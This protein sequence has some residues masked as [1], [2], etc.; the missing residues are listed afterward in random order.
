MTQCPTMTQTKLLL[1]V[2]C[3][4]MLPEGTTGEDLIQ[5]IAEGP[6]IPS[7]GVPSHIGLNGNDIADSLAKSATAD[8]LRGDACLTFAELSSIKRM[9]LNALWRVP[10]AHSWYFGSKSCWCHQLNIPRDRQTALSRFLVATSSLILL[11]RAGKSFRN[12]IDARLIKG[13]L[14]S[15]S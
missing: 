5:L 13:L 4:V 12:D 7:K 9:E 1:Q 10:P 8:A 3:S 2:R 11:N 6:S 14:E 15:Y